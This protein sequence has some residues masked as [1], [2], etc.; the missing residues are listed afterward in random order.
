MV[1][2]IRLAQSLAFLGKVWRLAAPYWSS[3]ERWRARGLLA[4]IVGLTLGLVYILVLLNDW[5]RSFYNALEQRDFGAFQELLLRF[6]ILAAIYITAAVY[7]LYFTQML[8]MRWRAWLTQEYIRDWLQEQVYYRLE[9]QSYGTDNPDQRIAE[10]LRI[11]ASNTLS[12]SLGLLSAVVKL[13][14]FVVILWAISGPLEFAL[15]GTDLSI[16]GYMVWVA[17]AYAVVGSV[18]THLVGRPLIGLNFQQQRREA[19]FRFR[20]VR[21]RENAEGVALYGGERSEQAELGNRFE[22]IRLNWWQLMRYTK[23][24]TSFTVGYSQIAIIFPILVAAPRYFAGAISLGGLMQTNQAFA[25]VENSLSWFVQSYGLIAE[26][27]AS[28]D[29]LLTFRDALEQARAAGARADGVVVEKD[30][31]GSVRAE[32]LELALPNGRVMLSDAAFAVEPGERVLLTGPSGSGKS[33]LFRVLAGIWP[34]GRGRIRVP[35]HARVLFLPQKPYI[36]I[37]TLREA[38]SYPATGGTFSDAEI[39]DV[40][41]A[42]QLEGFV[43]RLDAAE[44][45][46]LQLSVG[47]QQRLALAR[48]LLHKPDWLFLDEAT[49]ALDEPTEQHLYEVLGQR[50]PNAT[51][52]SIAHRP[53]LAGHHTRT[54]ALVPNGNRVELATS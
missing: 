17:I 16:P 54:F 28:V 41:A 24:L 49:A 30:A 8:E 35:E 37:A 45:W 51:I 46:S 4:A 26:W 34:F 33:T 5:N 14:S 22:G 53:K 19:D 44:N 47:E 18:L 10:D 52:V 39:R 38:V 40:L 25:Q 12:L 2:R 36:P 21:L 6:S 13:I 32:A 50:L 20:L 7:K 11:F 31:A 48:A 9:L 29:R 15:L 1:N 43:D 3:E 23:H 42:T 27:K